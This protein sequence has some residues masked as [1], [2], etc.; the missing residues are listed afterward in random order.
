MNFIG[1]MPL[2]TQTR[3]SFQYQEQALSAGLRDNGCKPMYHE[4]DADLLIV[5]TAVEAA[6]QGATSLP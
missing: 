4:D 1:A 6:S 2:K 3:L 5:Q